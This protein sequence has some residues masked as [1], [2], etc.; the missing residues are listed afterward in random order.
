MGITL[1][2]AAR[3]GVPVPLHPGRAVAQA[4][5]C[6]A[7]LTHGALGYTVRCLD[8]LARTVPF[9]HNVFVIDNASPDGTVEWLR[10]RREKNLHAFASTKNLGVAGGRNALLDS[11]APHL[12]E[13]G[14]VVFLDNDLEFTPGWTTPFLDVFERFPQAGVAGV[15]GQDILVHEKGR[16]LLPAAKRTMPVDVVS[17]GFACWVR[18]RAVADVGRFDPRTGPFWH[19][20]DD[21][22]VRALAAGWDVF[23]VPEARVLHHEHQSGHALPGL[24]DGGSLENQAYL[25]QKW[26]DAG[27]IDDE[28]W[29]VQRSGRFYLPP[30]Q[31][32][33]LATR[34]VGRLELGSACWDVERL[35]CA[36]DPSLEAAMRPISVSPVHRAL[37]SLRLEQA[38]GD[39][40]RTEALRACERVFDRESAGAQALSQ[41]AP[42]VPARESTS[43]S[44]GLSKICDADDWEDDAWWDIARELQA[45]A[46]AFRDFTQRHRATWEATQIA[47][48]L[49]RQGCL[50]ASAVG[51]SVG[52]GIEPLLWWLPERVRLLVAV[53][54]YDPNAEEE[55]GVPQD[56][57][58]DPAAHAPRPF[59][60][61]RLRVLSMDARLLEFGDATFDFVYCAA[62]LHDFG[63]AH[64]S[65]IALAEMAR[66][67][68]PGGVVALSTD[69]V[70][71]G[72]PHD[73]AFKPA[74]LA[75]E[76]FAGTGLHL[77]EPF[78][79]SI[80]PR[81]LEGWVA[82]DVER[83]PH[84]LVPSGN[85]IVSSAVVFARKEVRSPKAAAEPRVATAVTVGIDARTL[86]LSSSASRG[87]GH[88][89]AHHLRALSQLRPEWRFLC[90]GDRTPGR[91]LRGLLELSNVDFAPL[92]AS[93]SR[94]VD[95][96]HVPD[97]MNLSRGFDAPMRMFAGLRTSVTFH[98]LTPLRCYWQ[99]WPREDRATYLAR[100]DQLRTSSAVLTN[101]EYTRTDLIAA[102]RMPGSRVHT[103]LA[104]LNKDAGTAEPSVEEIA[105][106]RARL[107]LDGPFFLHVGALDAH[108]NFAGVLNVFHEV[109]ATTP[110]C[111]LVVAGPVDGNMIGAAKTCEREGI[112][113][114]VFAGFLP[115]TELE[116]LYASATALLFLSFYEGFGFPALEAMARGCPVI[117]SNT[118]SLPEVV[119][120]AGLQFHPDDEEGTA[121][122]MVELMSRP[123]L[124]RELGARGVERAVAFTWERTAQRTLDV[125][126]AVLA[127]P[128]D[129]SSESV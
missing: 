49:A 67:V 87:I 72:R 15:A 97:P 92:G 73:V 76:M 16:E 18:A 10:S 29:V 69:V 40:V 93:E 59:P 108:K 89:T 3:E 91:A 47:A 52:A 4:P 5:V 55:Y 86:Y 20:D 25:A 63:D 1:E 44:V 68:K 84:F 45:P 95:L 115:R 120:D 78:D 9:R 98:D 119:G 100:L 75:G 77:I 114:V 17:G 34:P 39:A 65:A 60:K 33:R 57:L 125:W 99:A 62:A 83:T 58:K 101:S 94:K 105:A 64:Q 82:G 70:V 106:V 38:Q 53:D 48:G 109:A 80:S 43:L 116:A 37:V 22:C 74:E 23:A 104:G 51:L 27:W 61:E 102:L 103:I 2:S 24:A 122:A 21:Y 110:G 90:L 124:C 111:R 56:L 96:L 41:L 50:H 36:D 42:D 12:P 46:P 123:E 85:A 128:L 30:Q 11:I 71:D 32:S 112:E 54:L 66:V 88:Y 26:R 7:I 121:R 81:T 117:T 35:C 19:E 28:G 129:P 127:A 13:D 118:S 107:G 6:F 113:G 14:F 126:E 31:R 8:T 79:S